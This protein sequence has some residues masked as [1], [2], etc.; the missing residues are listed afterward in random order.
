MAKEITQFSSH[1]ELKNANLQKMKDE[2]FDG[3]NGVRNSFHIVFKNR[4]L[5]CVIYYSSAL[6]KGCLV[7]RINIS[8]SYI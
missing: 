1:Q 3:S 8:M 6:T 4:F 5:Y 2:S 7:E